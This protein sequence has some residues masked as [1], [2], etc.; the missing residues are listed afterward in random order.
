MSPY[1]FTNVLVAIDGS[2]EAAKALDCA[3]SICTALDARLT[4]LAVEGKLPAY[5]ASLGEVDEV[6]REKDEFFDGVLHAARYSAEQRGVSVRTDLVPGHSADVI[7]HYAV[8]HAHDLIV[9][10]HHAHLLGDLLLGSTAD[11]VAH[12]ASCPVMVVR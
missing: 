5:A 3:L 10:A 2:D 12:H 9:V 11:R 4:V 8:A 7:V 1:E 6:K